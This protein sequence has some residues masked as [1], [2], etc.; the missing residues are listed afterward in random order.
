MAKDKRLDKYRNL[1]PADKFTLQTVIALHMA[2]AARLQSCVELDI[3]TTAD[4][5]YLA[6]I[7]HDLEREGVKITR[8]ALELT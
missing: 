4:V 1:T 8:L 5:V 7:G 2:T 6:K 3:I